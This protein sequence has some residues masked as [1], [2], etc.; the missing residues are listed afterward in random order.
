MQGR[1]AE[2]G[3]GRHWCRTSSLE[4]A[5]GIGRHVANQVTMPTFQSNPLNSPIHKVLKKHPGLFGVPFLVLIVGASFGLT[6]IT[7]TRYDL[8]DQKF[9]Q[10]PTLSSLADADHLGR[11]M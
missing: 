3:N 10:V 6:S 8:H 11:L 2:I 1:E 5:N 7:Q 4:K 9:Q